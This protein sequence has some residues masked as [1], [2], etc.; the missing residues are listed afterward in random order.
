MNYRSWDHPFRLADFLH[1]RWM[2]FFSSTLSKTGFTRMC[3]INLDGYTFR[4]CAFIGC[5]LQTSKGNFHIVDCHITNYTVYFVG[6]ALRIAKLS[7]MLLDSW[8]NLNEGIRAK[9]E[10]DDGVTIP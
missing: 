7:S 4:N 6:N 9:V 1:H 2:F 3:R 5:I 10:P 8:G